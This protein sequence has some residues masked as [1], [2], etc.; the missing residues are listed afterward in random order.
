Y[1][2]QQD[3]TDAQTYL[4]QV[5]NSNAYGLE[6]VFTDANGVNGNNG[7]ESVFEVGAIA[8][9]SYQG[10]GGQYGNTQ[11][12]RGAPNRGW[13]F[14]RPSVEL[15]KSFE[16]G[17]PRK[18]G[19]IIDIG[20]TLDGVLIQGE[21]ISADPL[22]ITNAN[23]D[24]VNIQCYNRKVWTPGDDVTSQWAFHRRLIR[25]AD[26]LL[27][28]AEVLNENGNQTQALVYLNMI[29]ARARQGNNAIL[30]NIT[31][32]NQDPLRTKILTERRHELALEG[33]R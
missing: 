32:T 19:T 15:R 14:N 8:S 9:Q 10:G 16:P 18:K 3:Y 33:F 24:T 6:P 5:I 26:V 27:M 20:D 17:D 28:A 1:L 7:V 13:G 30:P 4:M 29:R 22:V 25:Y 11:G 12:V 2:F 21:N 31:T 23:G